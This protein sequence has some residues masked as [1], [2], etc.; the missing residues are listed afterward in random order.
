M[1]NIPKADRTA[2]YAAGERYRFVSAPTG[3]FV[4]FACFRHYKEHSACDN[5]I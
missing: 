3:L 5:H 1:N 4:L 2:Y